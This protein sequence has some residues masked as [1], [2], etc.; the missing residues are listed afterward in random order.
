MVISI[1]E[2]FCQNAWVDKTTQFL[3]VEFIL[4]SETSFLLK[5]RLLVSYIRSIMHTIF[6]L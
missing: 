3:F 1:Y 4:Q 2:L 5:W 6:S